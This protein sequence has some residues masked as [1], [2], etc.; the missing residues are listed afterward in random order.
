MAVRVNQ[1]SRL[2]FADLFLA[3]GVEFWEV[4]DLP[5]IPEQDDDLEYQI[6]GGLQERIDRL[7]T[8]F[9]GEPSL[10]WVIA[11][12]NNM[13]IVPTDFSEGDIIVIPS[14]RFVLQELFTQV[15]T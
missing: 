9:Y 3:E 5:H 1:R 13:D 8:R 15:A 7:A 4:L 12:R 6:Q 2:R 11:A 10:W 14:P